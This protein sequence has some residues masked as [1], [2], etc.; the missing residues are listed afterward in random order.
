MAILVVGLLAG[1]TSAVEVTYQPGPDQAVRRLPGAE[2]VSLSVAV[3][4]NRAD[5]RRSVY[6]VEGWTF[7]ARPEPARVVRRTLEDDFRAMGFVV[8][9]EGRPGDRQVLV[10]LRYFHAEVIM[11]VVG[12]TFMGYVSF[13][14]RVVDGT[15]R[16][17]YQQRYDGEAE[18]GSMPGA[19]G[20]NIR[21]ALEAALA[22]AM[23]KVNADA[24][25]RQALL[26]AA[27]GL[28]FPPGR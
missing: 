3:S 23:R 22:E 21:V 4:D 25:L 12:V 7:N 9:P 16:P 8:A 27:G 28:D 15:G 1:C 20:R 13:D 14:V 2:A 10:G 6:E 17:L 26:A 19:P 24:P 18:G 5:P 11:H